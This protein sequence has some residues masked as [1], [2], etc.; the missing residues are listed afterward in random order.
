MRWFEGTP[1]TILNN[2]QV[3]PAEGLTTAQV[4]ERH[5]EYG[6]NQFDEEKPVPLWKK[7]L[8]HLK[9]AA[10]IIL[11][12]A[13][14]LSL[15]MDI[16]QGGNFI[17]PG[18]I[19][20]IV[21]MN[22][23]LAITQEA[24]AEKA[25]ASLAKMSSPSAK[26]IRD[27]Q[28]VE[29]D[30]TDVVP[31]D[32][33]VLETGDL[34]PAD[35]RLIE[36][37]DLAVD[38]ASL[39][40]ESEPSE[41]EMNP[42]FGEGIVP[43]GDQKNMV[44]SSC[45][46]I[47]GRA[48][49]VVVAT[50]MA[51]EMGKIAGYLNNTQKLKT[52]L[53]NRLDKIGKTISL[54]AVAAAFMLLAIGLVQGTDTWDIIFLAV[55]L[56]V[57]AVPEMLALIVTLTLSH[58]VK[59]MVKKNALIRKL[60][61]VETL[62]STSVI[63]SDKTGTL[64]QN[65]MTIT[66]LWLG[67]GEPLAAEAMFTD[68]AR[69][70]IEQFSL[71]SNAVI[72][73][74]DDGT[75][76]HFGNPTET[77][78]NRLLTSKGVDRSALEAEYPRVWEIPFSSERKMMTTIHED[79][80]GGYLVLTKGAMDRL[81][82]MPDEAAANERVRVH[83]SLAA[84][85]LRVLGLGRKHLDVSLAEIE[86]MPSEEIESNLDFVGIIGLI[87]PPRPE[88]RDAIVRARHA[89][90][91]TVMITGDHATTAKA[92]AVDL[93]IIQDNGPVMTGAEL[94]EISDDRLVE[95]VTDYSVYARVSPEDKIR[96]V[97]AWQEHDEVVAMTGDGVNDAPALKA[98]DVGIAM[99]ITGT[100][101]SKN[102]SDM[103]L[104]DDN[105]ATIVDAVQE[106]RNVF[107]IIKKLIYFLITCNFAEVII[108]VG[109]FSFGWGAIVTPVLILLINVLADGIPGLRLPQEISDSR[110][111]KRAPIGRT[112]S[113]FDGGLLF[114]IGKQVLAFVAATWTA[115]YLAAN[116]VISSGVAPSHGVGQSVAFVTLAFC[117]VLHIFTARTRA[118]IFKKSFLDNWPLTVSAFAMMALVASFVLLPPFRFL[119]DLTPIGGMHWLLIIG[120]GIVPTIVAE[121]GKLAGRI[122]ERREF[123]NRLVRHSVLHS[124]H[125]SRE[126]HA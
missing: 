125:E 42:G 99:G 12:L 33:I 102:A 77:A 120:L 96:I 7:I 81:P 115:Y 4:A 27:G 46:V 19:F 110:I 17:K 83:D 40:G 5:Q 100:E 48:R 73:P 124:E 8:H 62:G 44:F 6:L 112:E 66:R 106:G 67:E 64:T 31:G 84:Q 108:I 119:F 56:A 15:V 25:L 74:G 86:A 52:P 21:A 98:A 91:R 50:G 78:I 38:E 9:D 61:A 32:I 71:A 65:R 116:V 95:I 68:P 60:P 107:S 75:L 109:A 87:D 45:L 54:I 72:K 34:V 28:Q 126:I 29:I 117:A 11:L 26:V 59:Q 103:I 24:S 93:G 14:V 16:T 111:M 1:A 88:A 82:F 2:F 76:E 43:L 36:S 89:G 97:E 101:V 114:V 22:L 69:T 30:A 18:V 90:I 10:V 57:A 58:G 13:V 121:L 104:I 49:A 47:S 113:F 53:Q 20:F 92:I 51:T 23:T 80:Q 94:A 63:C 123:K 122:N 35:A 105:F 85:A 118:S 3:D 70:A 55:A 79:P 37:T 41:K 39:T